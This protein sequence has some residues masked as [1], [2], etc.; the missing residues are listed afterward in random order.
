MSSHLQSENYSLRH[1]L[2]S[3]LNEARRNEDK[4]RRFD[5]LQRRLIG[6]DSLIN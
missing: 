4:M 5:Q 6:A 3:L 1:Q 2:E